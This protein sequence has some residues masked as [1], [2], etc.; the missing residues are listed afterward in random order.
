MRVCLNCKQRMGAGCS[1]QPTR[2]LEARGE[3]REVPSKASNSAE[4][5]HVGL[6]ARLLERDLERPLADGVALAEC[7]ER[8]T[9][10]ERVVA[11]DP[12]VRGE[13][14][15]VEPDPERP[16]VLGDRLASGT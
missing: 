10:D 9:L 4:R 11:L 12:A 5:E 3:A 6:G 16:A 2:I 8:L 1:L 14:E 15:E 7:R 13:D